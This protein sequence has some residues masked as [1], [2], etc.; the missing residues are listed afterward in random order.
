MELIEFIFFLSSYILTCAFLLVHRIFFL[1]MLGIRSQQY[2]RSFTL[3][4]KSVSTLHWAV[5]QLTAAETDKLA[6]QNNR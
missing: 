4:Q 5:N 6:K 1:G 2:F 3:A